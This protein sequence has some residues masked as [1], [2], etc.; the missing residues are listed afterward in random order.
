MTLWV[1]FKEMT[2]ILSVKENIS[3]NNLSLAIYDTKSRIENTQLYD[4]LLF[5]A[6][7]SLLHFDRIHERSSFPRIL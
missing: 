4:L 2:E 3:I 6:I 5:S 1:Y 7:R